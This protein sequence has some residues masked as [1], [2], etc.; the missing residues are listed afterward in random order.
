MFPKLN[1]ET[2]NSL[3]KA[4][5]YEK[6]KEREIKNYKLKKYKKTKTI[7]KNG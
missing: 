1:F 6:K 2:I 7:Y 4:D 5:L 3:E